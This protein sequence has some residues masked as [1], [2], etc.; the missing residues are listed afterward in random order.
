MSRLE[1][2]RSSFWFLPAVLCLLAVVLAEGLVTL[3]EQL[4]NRAGGPL[5]VLL[6][7][8][9]ASGSRDL[10]GAIAGSMLGVA[11]TTFSITIAVL[12]LSSSTYGPRLV[13]NF[14][15][16]R[17]NQMVL[18]IF[19]STFLYAL[20][21]LRT[22]RTEDDDGDGFVPHLATNAAVVLAVVAIGVLVYFIHHISDSIQI[23]TLTRRLRDELHGCV[24]RLYPADIGAG[25]DDAP[26]PT[27]GP[28]GTPDVLDDVAREGVLVRA[29]HSGYVQS[30]DED[31]L[32]RLAT[33]RDLVVVLRIR[34]G[35]YVVGEGE[36]A[37]LWPPGRADDEAGDAVLAT[38]QV[39]DART[40]QQDIEFAAQQ[41]VDMAVRALSPST[42]DP[43][44]AINALDDL[45]SGLAALAA[46]TMPSTYRYDDD[47]R[48]R[49]VAVRVVLTDLLDQ[50]FDAMR[51][52]GLEH[53]SVLHHTLELGERVR[54]RSHDL[55]VHERLRTNVR[56]LVDA[57]SRS[58]PQQHDLDLLRR[59]ADRLT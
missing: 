42:N 26:S 30:I 29:A 56:L 15:A 49:V 5:D 6:Y 14:M 23:A 43:Y 17:G 34:P 21:V 38:L 18:G 12:A 52:Y 11:S 57:Y 53:P 31:E 51:L 40:P 2:V 41:L 39:T 24:D 36:V 58:D 25:V 32:F 19:V 45:S 44:T 47:G 1:E 8:V 3:D 35:A 54:D 50:V 22:V 4:Q 7:R 28:A 10:L 27:P 48:L 13:R 59:H 16:D 9:G 46:R 33:E 20:L 37:V 55:V